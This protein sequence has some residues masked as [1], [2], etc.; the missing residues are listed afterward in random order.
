MI[1]TVPLPTLEEID[2]VRRE[3]FRP[4]VVACLLHHQRVLLVYKKKH[5][6]WML[7]QGGVD[8]HEELIA[9]FYREIKEEL[10]HKLVQQ[11]GDQEPQLLTEDRL[12]FRWEKTQTRE[13]VNDAGDEMAMKGK[14][15]Y[16]LVAKLKEAVV[17]LEQSEFDQ[18]IWADSHRAEQ[19]FNKI[20][21]KNKKVILQQAI[22]LLKKRDLIK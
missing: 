21:F 6:L 10:G 14:H 22:N 4:T 7:P 15:Y 9:A 1:A 8:N 11:L 20:Y 3:N 13:L 12:V 19:I 18:A 17:N 2:Q 16:V 5:R